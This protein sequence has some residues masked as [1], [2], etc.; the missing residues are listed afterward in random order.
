MHPLLRKEGVSDFVVRTAG[1]ENTAGTLQVRDGGQ[2]VGFIRKLAKAVNE[3]TGF[4]IRQRR[5]EAQNEVFDFV[6]IGTAV[7]TVVV[8]VGDI[9]WEG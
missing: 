1:Y 8:V 7:T 9:G 5:K 4:C 6:L 3:D 2:E